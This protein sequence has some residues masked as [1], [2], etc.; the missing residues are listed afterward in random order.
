MADTIPQGNER[1]ARPQNQSIDQPAAILLLTS[2]AHS[3]PLR[4]SPQLK[5]DLRRIENPP[6]ALRDSHTG[7]SKRLREH[8]RNHVDFVE[9]LS[10]AES[11]IRAVMS[12]A[13]LA[14]ATDDEEVA[15]SVAGFCARGQHRSVAFVE[16]LAALKWPK[17]WEVR[18]EHRDLQ[19][20]R[21]RKTRW[22]RERQGGGGSILCCMRNDKSPV[23]NKFNYY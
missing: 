10:H 13:L 2:H 8:L 18:V 5:Y 14:G 11:D 19:R 1:D 16:E 12:A 23:P 3:P 6:K 22:A 21:E 17:E 15:L 4:P 20:G 9:M 7:V